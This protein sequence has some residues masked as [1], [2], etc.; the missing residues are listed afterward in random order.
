MYRPELLNT[1]IRKRTI[2]GRSLSLR[3]TTNNKRNDECINA[4]INYMS[5]PAIDIYGA[6]PYLRGR[7]SL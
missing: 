7:A 6:F 3:S 4:H 1:S 2:H 5:Q